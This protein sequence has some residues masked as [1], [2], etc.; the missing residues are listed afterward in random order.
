MDSIQLQNGKIVEYD[1]SL[2]INGIVAYPLIKMTTQEMLE[3]RDKLRSERDVVDIIFNNQYTESPVK[4]RKT[5]PINSEAVGICP[6]CSGDVFRELIEVGDPNPDY[7]CLYNA[8]H[9][10][11]ENNPKKCDYCIQ[12]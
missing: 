7:G 9:E 6:K 4:K 3:F 5:S 8:W 10:V 2:R 1:Y 11:C 12:V